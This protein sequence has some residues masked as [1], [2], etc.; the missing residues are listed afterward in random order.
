M[1]CLNQH[2]SKALFHTNQATRKT[3]FNNLCTY[4]LIVRLRWSHLKWQELK[5]VWRDPTTAQ[6]TTKLE[7]PGYVT[8]FSGLKISLSCPKASLLTRQ[9]Y[10][11][12]KVFNSKAH[13][14]SLNIEDI[15]FTTYS[16][17]TPFWANDLYPDYKILHVPLHSNIFA[18]SCSYLNTLD[19]CFAYWAR[20]QGIVAE[21]L[22][23]L[24]MRPGFFASCMSM[25]VHSA[26]RQ[27]LFNSVTMF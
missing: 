13:G 3:H 23:G 27:W 16:V 12:F 9:V 4:T 17:T 14:G 18:S 24:E 8:V 2:I 21:A 5:Y 1:K 22:M 25:G 15:T 26:N 7:Y 20:I 10:L 6:V 19:N 11:S